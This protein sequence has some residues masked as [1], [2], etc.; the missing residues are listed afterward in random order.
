MNDH[1]RLADVDCERAMLS[2]A[3]LAGDFVM[4]LRLEPRDFVDPLCRWLHGHLRDLVEADEP[5][6]MVALL[7]RVRLPDGCDGLSASEIDALPW[8]IGELLTTATTTAHLEYY[9][10]VL[11][12][13]RLRRAAARLAD[14]IR[15][16]ITAQMQEPAAV[17]AWAG[18]QVELLLARAPL[19]K[20]N[21]GPTDGQAERAAGE[22]MKP[23]LEPSRSV[24]LAVPAAARS[25]PSG[26]ETV[27]PS[28]TGR[29]ESLCQVT[30]A[31]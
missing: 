22:R 26:N 10:G 21:I 28:A 4:M 9:F 29:D 20:P 19:K 24:D 16:R 5:L 15:E 13:E 25:F 31:E 2:S 7:R 1:P 11:R 6:T 8:S 14:A 23:A 3:W 12:T 17:L 18:E 27:R 30:A